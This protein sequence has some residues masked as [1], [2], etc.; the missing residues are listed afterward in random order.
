M[1][2]LALLAAATVLAL[3]SCGP[4]GVIPALGVLPG[5]GGAIPPLIAPC[6]GWTR[7]MGGTSDDRALAL[8]ADG[9]GNVY[10]AGYFDSASV[11]FAADFG[12]TDTKTNAGGWDVFVT[13]IEP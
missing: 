4:V 9:S 5:R 1:R 12:W 11:D 6:Y 8:C 3:C 2:R 13:K 7:R 10:V